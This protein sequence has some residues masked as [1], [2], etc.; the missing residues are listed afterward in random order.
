MSNHIMKIHLW[1]IAC[2]LLLINPIH[3]QESAVSP[4]GETFRWDSSLTLPD[5]NGKPH[6]GLGGH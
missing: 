2:L 4:S 6:P 1:L 3:A 5:I